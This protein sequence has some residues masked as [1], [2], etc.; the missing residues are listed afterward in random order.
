MIVTLQFHEQTLQRQENVR[1]RVADSN[2][3]SLTF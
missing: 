3:Y 2:R 1:G